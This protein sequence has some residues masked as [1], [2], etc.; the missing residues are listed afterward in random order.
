M[1]FFMEEFSCR[2]S[3]AED[4]MGLWNTTPARSVAKIIWTK[5]VN[6][7]IPAPALKMSME[8]SYIARPA[9]NPPAR[10]GA[11]TLLSSVG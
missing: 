9:G 1:E 4:V 6:P 5:C 3:N 7:T 2:D 11:T 10:A 8:A